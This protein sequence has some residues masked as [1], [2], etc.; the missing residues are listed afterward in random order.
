MLPL[1]AAIS[2]HLL[3]NA[4]AKQQQQ[5]Q[6]LHACT[7]VDGCKAAAE[8]LQVNLSSNVAYP[9]RHEADDNS[10]QLQPRQSLMQVPLQR[11]LHCPQ[12]C[13]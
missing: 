9:A 11:C 6:L 12:L 4:A 10:P 8:Q 2:T 5:K 3:S 13:R 1:I 7:H